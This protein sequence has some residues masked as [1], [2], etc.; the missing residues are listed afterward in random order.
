MILKLLGNKHV[1]MFWY[2]GMINLYSSL[3]YMLIHKSKL[4]VF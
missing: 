2:A 3:E 4:G 1:L